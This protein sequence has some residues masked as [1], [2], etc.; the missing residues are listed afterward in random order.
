MDEVDVFFGEDCCIDVTCCARLQ[1]GSPEHPVAALTTGL[2]V[3]ARGVA[4]CEGDIRVS[5]MCLAQTPIPLAGP[6]KSTELSLSRFRDSLILFLIGR[7][8]ERHLN[9]LSMAV[10]HLVPGQGTFPDEGVL[11]TTTN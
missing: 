4:T 11:R 10:K 5:G 6:F 9:Y 3:S 1:S 2:F 8:V 7:C